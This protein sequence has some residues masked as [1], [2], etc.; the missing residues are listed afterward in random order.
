[1]Q[2]AL[3]HRLRQPSRPGRPYLSA[4][5]LLLALLA[6][7]GCGSSSHADGTE[8]D[9]ATAV[10]AAAPLYLGV[11]VRPSGSERSGALAAGLDLTGTAN[12]YK[13]LLGLLRTTGSPPLNFE[14]DVAPW[15][16]PHA[17]LYLSSLGSAEALL[18]P[19][20]KALAG[21]GSLEGL[22]FSSGGLDGA[23]VMDT[24]DASAAR[25]FLATQAKRAH[26]HS[27]SYRG[28]SYEVASGGLAFGLV[29]RL[30]VIGSE[31]GLRGVIGT[32]QGE[33]ALSAAGGYGKLT[34][35]APSEAIGHLY[36]NPGVAGAAGKGASSGLLALLGSGRQANVS[37]RASA[38]RLTVD[39]DTLAASSGPRSAGGLLAY[40]PEAA[41]ALSS[42][43]GE[44]WLAIGLGHVGTNLAADA[45]GLS[46][47]GSLT[48]SEA[49]ASSTISIGA[50]LGGLTKP[51]QILGAGTASAKRDFT[52]W[53]GSGG[54][55]AAGSSVLELKAGVVI[56][57]NDPARSRAAVGKLGAALRKA[58]DEVTH[59]NVAGAEAAESVRLPGVP[60]VVY[61][62][63]GQSQS[64]ARFVLA[65]GEAGVQA[66]LEP[67]STLSGTAP[68][69]AA[70]A[71][72]GEGIKPS[73]MADFPTLLALLEGV[74]LTEDPTVAPFL[75]YL[76]ASSTLSGGG[77]AL[78]GGVERFRVVLGLNQ[79]AAG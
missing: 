23:L 28:V 43:P 30:A 2:R 58:G 3:L 36:V 27:T 71:T 1:M 55:F 31:A 54:V 14:R 76:R 5:A 13:R 44:S 51:L 9:P 38:G 61:I 35:A 65:L 72:L 60:L 16:G 24:R 42:L 32:T 48:G 75:P 33:A 20:Q 50:L 41:Q 10:P 49:S 17:G 67:Q 52:G 56:S 64:G 18:A 69:S 63:A 12:P 74:G 39:V 11:T 40:D 26:A 22:S 8:A 62:A 19:L 29:G 25:A 46:A 73:L 47:L 57:S 53:M 37:L 78:S 7:A 34:A 68:Q 79:P 59:A 4:L 21:S 45:A 66:A 6:L 70:T 77:V 15:L